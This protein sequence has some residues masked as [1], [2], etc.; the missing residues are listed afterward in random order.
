[1]L[2]QLALRGLQYAAMKDILLL[3]LATGAGSYLLRLLWRYVAEPLLGFALPFGYNR[4]GRFDEMG[5]KFLAI[6]FAMN[7]PVWVV[8]GVV[9]YFFR[10]RRV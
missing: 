1:M 2:R 10:R 5:M 8:A 6:D 7:V 3:A 9:M 4:Y